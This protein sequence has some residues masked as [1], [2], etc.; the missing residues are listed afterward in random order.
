MRFADA[1]QVVFK[2]ALI[3]TI[4]SLAPAGRALAQDPE[5]P[6]EIAPPPEPDPTPT[7]FYIL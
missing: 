5:P 3:A 6:P 1:A 4:V 7:S 2:A